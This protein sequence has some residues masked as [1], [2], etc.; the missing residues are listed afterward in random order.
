[1]TFKD[2]F[3][4]SHL[5]R[6]LNLY[7]EHKGWRAKQYAA[8]S[9][10][11]VKQAVL[12]R[13]A[14]QNATWIETGTYLGQTTEVLSKHG[15]FVYS[16]EPEPTLYANALTRFESAQ[17]VKIINGISEEVFPVLL[18][19]LSGKI[20]FF[21]D[22]HYSGGETFA[23]PNDCP[24]LDELNFI[25]QNLHRFQ[26]VSILIDDIRLC[27]K[28]HSYGLYPSLDNLVDFAR[29]NN[30]DWH[31]EHDIFVANKKSIQTE[32]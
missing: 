4:N 10:H 18:P 12:L 2:M 26:A 15:A 16:I 22:G 6:I 21:L 29:V 32:S 28:R 7:L 23:G 25:S 31:I 24:L 20:N 5:R 3:R 14:F 19:K 8:P 11:F 1:M 17:N 13:N 9:P 30:L 27:G